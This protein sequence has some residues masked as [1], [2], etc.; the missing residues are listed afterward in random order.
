MVVLRMLS[1]RQAPHLYAVTLHTYQEAGGQLRTRCPSIEQG[2]GGVGEPAFTQ[3]VVRLNGALN[4][5]LVHANRDS[6]EHVLRPLHYCTI[7]SQ[8]V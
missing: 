6:H 5:G 8:Q 7:H 1:T 2:W 4:V 3:Q